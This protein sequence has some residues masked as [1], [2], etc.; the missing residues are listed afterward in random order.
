M[1]SWIIPTDQPRHLGDRAATDG[2]YADGMPV[3]LFYSPWLSYGETTN[4]ITRRDYPAH[5]KNG[6]E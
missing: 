5:R 2:T 1:G 4:G 3:E 6:K